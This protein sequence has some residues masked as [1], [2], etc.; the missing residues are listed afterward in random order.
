[1][2]KRG[3][4]TFYVIIGIIIVT[5]IVL[6]VGI[7]SRMAR[8][9]WEAERLK[10][11]EIPEE[12]RDVQNYILSCINSVG[13]EGINILLAQGGY[14]NLPEEYYTIDP[15]LPYA[16]SLEIIPG[17]GM[18]TSYWFYKYGNELLKYNKPSV[19][20]M[21]RQLAFYV[22]NNLGN[23]LQNFTIFEQYEIQFNSA[24]TNVIIRNENVLFTVNLPVNFV[25]EGFAF[26]LENFYEPVNVRLGEL[27]DS[28]VKV[29]DYIVHNDVFEELTY[30]SIVLD[31]G[32]P[33]SGT[34]FTCEPFV[35]Y[36]EDV[37]ESLKLVLSENIPYVKI[38]GTQNSDRDNYFLRDAGNLPNDYMVFFQ[39]IPDWPM[40][41]EIHPSEENGLILKSDSII[42]QDKEEF[43]LV[44]SIMC[45][46]DY[47]FVYNLVYPLL[48]NVV[49]E[50]GESMQ[51]GI[52][53]VIRNNQAKNITEEVLDFPDHEAIICGNKMA[54]QTVYVLTED[55]G[56]YKLLENVDINLKCVNAVCNVG[57]T[58]Y[59]RYT[60]TSMLRTNMPQ[61]FNAFMSAEKQ[62]YVSR[63]EMVSTIQEDQ[64]F[65]IFM[66]PVTEIEAYVV[67]YEDFFERPIVE[68]EEFVITGTHRDFDHTFTMTS[69]TSSINLIPGV[70]DIRSYLFKESRVGFTIEGRDFEYCYQKPMGIL[71]T[72]IGFTET[73]CKSFT[74]EDIQ[75]DSA[76][77]GGG[78]FSWEVNRFDLENAKRIKFRLPVKGFPET[79]DDF[80]KII[81]EIDTIA[82]DVVPRFEYE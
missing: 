22:D 13:N 63:P 42:S 65:M 35:W 32:V 30:D 8:L 66:E 57:K 53:V 62:G 61:C 25:G 17:S 55:K 41:L 54:M 49:N 20:E 31:E 40:D 27:Y 36:Y 37:K 1:M 12:A 59:D 2:F 5:S 19:S 75:A 58:V 71:G 45:M 10:S 3:Q 77:I 68:S 70:Y 73:E 69:Q 79:I 51:F 39:Y 16:K 82:I 24:K 44:S 56:G 7:R 33:L 47:S 52:H 9:D 60:G 43:A 38:K 67:A 64:M 76:I 18:R 80:D 6:I 14:I 15:N 21:E 78:E 46:Q 48:V 4:I 23:C 74:T 29:Y 50:K 72:L 26:S 11:M 81:E 34:E 28:A